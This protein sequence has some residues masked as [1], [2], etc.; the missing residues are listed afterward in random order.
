MI[1]RVITFTMD[2]GANVTMISQEMYRETKDGPLQST[3]HQLTGADCQPLDV[4]G[5][6]KRYLKHQNT[7]T[8]QD[9][10]VICGL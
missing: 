6:F 1:E 8:E 10:F 3:K 9:I 4:Q 5:H 2:T 7:E